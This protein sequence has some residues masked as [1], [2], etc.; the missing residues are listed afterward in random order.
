[1]N[2]FKSGVLHDIHVVSETAY[3]QCVLVGFMRRV[4]ALVAL[5]LLTG[6]ASAS[7]LESATSDVL[8]PLSPVTDPVAEAAS[9][10]TGLPIE[11][12]HLHV[13]ADAGTEYDAPDSCADALA[14]GL[15]FDLPVGG[16]LDGL[17]VAVD[18][19]ADYYRVA[20]GQE[21]VGGRVTLSVFGRDMTLPLAIDAFMPAC[22][23]S[24]TAPENQPAPPPAP[25][26]PAE[27]EVQ[28][29]PHNL[30]GAYDCSD[31][32]FF[33]LNQFGG[34]DAPESIHV[35]WTDGSQED[36]PLLKDTPA[37]LAQY[38]TSLHG[39]F[40]IESATAN[41]PADWKGQFNLSEGFCDAVDGEAVFGEP[42]RVSANGMSITFTPI[43]A[44]TYTLAVLSVPPE[45]PDVPTSIPLSCHFACADLPEGAMDL[46]GYTASAF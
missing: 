31:R 32:W 33:V 10:A 41:V 35:V 2:W 20:I 17:L 1:M 7:L 13:Q 11:L 5:L 24:V 16:D 30:G 3:Y 46:S 36:V 4:V 44:G 37:T 34:R 14:S 45:V 21:L 38:A 12:D 23:T 6:P 15:P 27:G 8:G 43:E 25:P 22:G 29:T 18:D 42:A 9:D 19:E 28:V 40:T 26:A 39:G